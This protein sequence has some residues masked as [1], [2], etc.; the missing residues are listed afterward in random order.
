MDGIR[1]YRRLLTA[2][3]A[4]GFL[5]V[6]L[7]AVRAEQVG[8]LGAADR[9]VVRGLEAI[10]SESLRDGLLADAELYW[11]GLPDADRDAYLEALQNRSMLALEAAGFSEPAVKVTVERRTDGG[12]TIAIDVVEGPRFLA[13]AIRVTGLP[14]DVAARLVR[15]L[16]EPQPP[17][18]SQAE[19]IELPDGSTKNHWITANGEPAKLEDPLWTPGKPAGLGR[20]RH[21]ALCRRTRDFLLREGFLDL[22]GDGKLHGF[23][24]GGRLL[25]YVP[26]ELEAI[27]DH[28]DLDVRYDGGQAVLA[29]H[30]KRLPPRSKL[31]AVELPD[32]LRTTRAEL[33]RYLGIEIGQPVTAADRGAWREK[34]R[35]SGRFVSQKIVFSLE[36]EGIVARFELVEY[37]D[38]TPLGAPISPEEEALRSVRAWLLGALHAGH[39]VRHNIRD[40]SLEA[41]AF[42]V[43]F[44]FILGRTAAVC[45]LRFGAARYGAAVMPDGLGLY[46][47]NAR[48]ESPLWAGARPAGNLTLDVEVKKAGEEPE[49]HTA[50]AAFGVG[51]R[52]G[53]S[54]PPFQIEPVW[55]T[56][57]ARRATMS[58]REGPDLVVE[59][60][61][62]SGKTAGTWRL[63]RDPATGRLLRVEAEGEKNERGEDVAFTI[64]TGAGLAA[65]AVAELQAASGPNLAD[66][67]RPVTAAARFVVALIESTPAAF[68]GLREH[69]LGAA[70]IESARAI[71]ATIQ[72]GA[73][74]LLDLG[75]PEPVE[76]AGRRLFADSSRTPPTDPLLIPSEQKPNGAIE[77]VE[78]LASPRM[79]AP[80]LRELESHLGR[81]AWPALAAR[82]A[83]LRFCDVPRAGRE[84]A[85]IVRDEKPALDAAAA[86]VAAAGGE[87]R[88]RIVTDL[89]EEIAFTLGDRGEVETSLAIYRPLLDLADETLGPDHPDTAKLINNV[90]WLLNQ[91][92][93]A[94]GAYALNR[95]PRA[96]IERKQA[97]LE[98]PGPARRQQPKVASGDAAKKEKSKKEK[99]EATGDASD[100]EQWRLLR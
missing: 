13:G 23:V 1:F 61:D 77:A 38:A 45:L 63:R 36:P 57:Q 59:H 20:E 73:Q 26:N 97:G 7:S 65:R 24:R 34:L 28:V 82:V 96:A 32:G 53:S 71:S 42:G 81:D 75:V 25:H 50:R 98:R 48:L 17:L 39:E 55:C 100:E 51:V 95:H 74:R 41:K 93:D 12:E 70:E 54:L 16:Q 11:L 89:C 60:A 19:S 10:Q 37:R 35:Q 92:G 99:A 47:P 67:S 44:D 88:R 90:V 80:L 64:E 22:Q 76:A 40:R 52:R 62:D 78:D 4:C 9:L 79:L 14:D 21:D 43:E 72:G 15:Y 8:D 2:A 29:I 5:L 68:D 85:R 49:T 87:P 83:V 27:R 58:R 46:A 3:G 56:A 6:A 84:V 69:G 91:S 86:A 33:E 18:D 31:A 94:A 30:V 66:P